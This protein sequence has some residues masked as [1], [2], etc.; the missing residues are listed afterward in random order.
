MWTIF[1]AVAIHM[2]GF[3]AVIPAMPYL[4][5]DLGGDAQTQG[6]LV[7][8]FA[9]LQL[10]TSPLWGALSD[11]VGRAAVASAGLSLSALGHLISFFAHSLGD[12]AMGRALAGV[13]AGT[14]PALQ[15]LM[16]DLTPPDRRASSMALFGVAFGVGLVAGPALGG[17][18]AAAGSRLPFLGAAVL[19]TAASV[20][21]ATLPNLR[22]LAGARLEF[23]LGLV[24]IPVLVVNLA[25][26]MFEGLFSYFAAFAMSMTPTQIGM[27]LAAAGVAA[28]ASHPLVKKM[29]RRLPPRLGAAAGLLLS[30][31][32]LAALA[33]SLWATYLLYVGVVA[34]TLGQIVASSFIY[35]ILA[36]GGSSG[37]KFG[38]V[39][40][41]ASLGRII[42]P[43]VGGFLYNNVGSTTPF[44]AGALL[45]I[46]VLPILAKTRAGGNT[47]E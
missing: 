47:Q 40:A 26:S 42:G 25:V 33:A 2:V 15:A 13:G 44:I 20:L 36:E 30:A 8:L 7:S 18:L 14:L 41:A 39:N 43:P 38:V 32:G 24:S 22:G 4:L 3:G 34:A 6:L 19:S 5:R 35:A 31:A 1:A 29:E 17:I 11:R 16:A 23:K 9:A 21:T 37:L 45:T 10:V 46:T 28:G 12:M 27:L